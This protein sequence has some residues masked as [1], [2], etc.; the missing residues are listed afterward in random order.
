MEAGGIDGETADPNKPIADEAAS[1]KRL[2]SEHNNENDIEHFRVVGGRAVFVR[3]GVFR[4]G[5][6]GVH[7]RRRG[8]ER[9][10]VFGVRDHDG[11]PGGLRVLGGEIFS[12]GKR[13]KGKV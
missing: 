12:G 3:D 7:L 6:A 1:R 9:A 4:R 11:L 2:R 10:A 8:V 5:V 13:A